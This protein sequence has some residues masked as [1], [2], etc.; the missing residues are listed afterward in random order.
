MLEGKEEFYAIG[1][2][3]SGILYNSAGGDLVIKVK[4]TGMPVDKLDTVVDKLIRRSI[5][6][7]KVVR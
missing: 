5:P 3:L 4:G 2:R 6:N 1:P 7:A